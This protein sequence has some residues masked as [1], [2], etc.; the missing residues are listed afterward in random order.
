MKATKIALYAIITGAL[1]MGG[2][3]H[4]EKDHLD[5]GWNKQRISQME[6]TLQIPH[7]LV[8]Q[9]EM[10]SNKGFESLAPVY[11]S[12]NNGITRVDF[13]FKDGNGQ[14]IVF[15]ENNKII[16]ATYFDKK[17]KRMAF[18]RNNEGRFEYAPRDFLVDS[19]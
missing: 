12:E 19:L 11:A 14:A 4:F 15:Y 9:A 18:K 16:K 17:G 1:T 8:R 13:E 7:D 5:Y 10:Y 6:S 3:K 2:I